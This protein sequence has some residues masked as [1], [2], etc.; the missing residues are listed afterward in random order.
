ME[1]FDGTIFFTS[2]VLTTRALSR[3]AVVG[4]VTELRAGRS[5]FAI[6]VGARDLSLEN[7]QA[8]FGVHPASYSVGTGVVSRG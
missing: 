7:V 4:I 2:F 5:R 3:G 8:G 1:N 6:P